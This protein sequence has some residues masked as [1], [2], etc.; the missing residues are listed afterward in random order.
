[1]DQNILDM[2]IISKQAK[3]VASDTPFETPIAL[4]TLWGLATMLSIKKR[5]EFQVSVIPEDMLMKMYYEHKQPRDLL[6][7][8][9]DSTAFLKLKANQILMHCL[10]L[11]IQFSTYNFEGRNM[12]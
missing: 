7:W 5:G 10:G 4:Y 12:D 2:D 9:A 1:M 11:M 3:S 8:M 6:E